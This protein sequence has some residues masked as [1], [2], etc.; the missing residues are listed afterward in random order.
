MM[1]VPLVLVLVA[2]HLA[3]VPGEVNPAVT[4]DTIHQTICV[5]G[6]TATIRPTVSY[7]NDLKRRLLAE[8]HLKGTIGD[9]ELDHFIPLEL[10]RCFAAWEL[11]RRGFGTRGLRRGK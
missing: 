10:G 8:Q 9:Y 7:T 3:P 4:Q 6:Y 1:L 5:S 2:T 11:L